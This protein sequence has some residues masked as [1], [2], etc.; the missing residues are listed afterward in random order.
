MNRFDP[1]EEAR[2]AMRDFGARTGLTSSLPPRRYLWTDAFAVCNYLSLHRR[3]GEESHLFAAR[4]LV[5]QVHGILGR[6]HPD[7]PRTGWLSGLDED[8]GALHPTTGG[9]RIGKPLPERAPEDPYD[10][11][12]EWERDGQYYHYLTKWMQALQRMFLVTTER[13]YL[14]WATDLALAAH[15]GF[16]LRDTEDM[17]PRLAWKMSVDLS[18]PLVHSMGAHDP[19]DGFISLAQLRAA[20]RHYEAPVR[21]SLDGPIEEL[22]GLCRR[23]Y[24]ATEDPLGIGGLLV[25]A[26]HLARLEAHGE[27]CQPALL[28]SL[29]DAAE[30]SLRYFRNDHPLDDPAETRLAFRELGLTIGLRSLWSLRDTLT[31]HEREIQGCGRHIPRIDAMARFTDLI[32]L[33]EDFWSDP[34]NRATSAWENHRDINEVMLATSLEPHMFL[35]DTPCAALHAGESGAREIPS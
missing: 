16:L 18:R 29:V 9:L 3:T 33:I 7:D 24:W 35:L 17:L 1:L 23:T 31:R 12:E 5:D 21:S 8:E 20:E 34:G 14:E 2:E 22:A 27:V 19:L 25:D 6:F 15:R 4:R 10:E 32:E 30:V 11:R 13:C 28:Q 26:H